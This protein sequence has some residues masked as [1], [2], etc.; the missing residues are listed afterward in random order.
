MMWAVHVARM[1][2]VEVYTGFIGVKGDLSDTVHLE[3]RNVDMKIIL[4]WTFKIWDGESWTGSILF[5][6]GTG[7]WLL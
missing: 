1:G 7:G 2:R 4:K 3:D 6:I 5:R